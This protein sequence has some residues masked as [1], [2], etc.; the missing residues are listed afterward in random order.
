LWS[1]REIEDAITTPDDRI[2]EK[3]KM[4][5]ELGIEVNRKNWILNLSIETI[6][7]RYSRLKELGLDPE[8]YKNRIGYTEKRLEFL[9]HLSLILFPEAANSTE[10]IQKM[11]EEFSKTYPDKIILNYNKIIRRLKL[12]EN[13]RTVDEIREYLKKYPG[14]LIAQVDDPDVYA[15]MCDRKKVKEDTKISKE[16][17]IEERRNRK[18]RI[19]EKELGTER[20]PKYL[21]RI[22][23][24]ELIERIEFIKKRMG[25]EPK[26]SQIF[27]MGKKRREQ[28][29]SD[30]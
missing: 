25:L 26:P 10:A 23:E 15:N 6:R 18:K 27:N 14:Y 3:M 5:E 20:I 8:E 30:E 21:L 7:N 28:I 1:K 17:Q 11:K 4:F 24:Q 13:T 9:E 2:Q 16:Q 19:L 22:G 12:L 29:M